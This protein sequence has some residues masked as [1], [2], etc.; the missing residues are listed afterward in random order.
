MVN[1]FQKL[2]FRIFLLLI[3]GSL[4]GC[5]SDY[6]IDDDIAKSEV[7]FIHFNTLETAAYM[8]MDRFYDIAKDNDDL[9]KI[10][11]N[12]VLSGTDLSDKYGNNLKNIE[13]GTLVFSRKDI[14]EVL[15]YQD[16]S[17]FNAN[18]GFKMGIMF[19]IQRLPG[20]QNLSKE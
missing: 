15:K 12:L 20:S 4:F 5:G 19:D 3:I 8:V 17:S 9:K 10:E 16:F 18:K 6:E 14:E 7:T 1:N 13:M 11:I 2:R